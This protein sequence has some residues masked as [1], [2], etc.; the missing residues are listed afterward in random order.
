MVNSYVRPYLD[1]SAYLAAINNEKDRALVVRQILDA[2]EQKKIQIV[3]STFVVA[4]VIKIKGEDAYLTPDKESEIDEVLKSERILWVELDLT[5]ALEARKLARAHGL[6][7]GDAIHLASAIR[8][9]ADV[10]LRYDS[11]FNSKNEI[12]GLELCDP[13][14]PG[15]TPFPDLTIETPK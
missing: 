14:W 7:P 6:K 10:L 9:K 2:A 11:R 15:D 12:A 4:E 8:A 13:F 3:A 5:L 1:T